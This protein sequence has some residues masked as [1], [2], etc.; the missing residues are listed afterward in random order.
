MT[1]N[2]H[3]STE[4]AINLFQEEADC[5]VQAGENLQSFHGKRHHKDLSMK[6]A[7]DKEIEQLE[8]AGKSS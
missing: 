5:L 6:L 2:P 7:N 3:T 1:L 8:K 4:Y